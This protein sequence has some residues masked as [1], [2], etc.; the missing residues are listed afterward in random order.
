MDDDWLSLS[1]DSIAHRFRDR[2]LLAMALT[3]PSYSNEGNPDIPDNQR[4]EWL[5]DAVV[6]LTVAAALYERLPDADEG[7]LTLARARVVS[8]HSLAGAARRLDLGLHL[9]LGRGAKNK[10]HAS[11][12]DS[13]LCAAF[14]AVVGAIFLDAGFEAARAFVLRHLDGIMSDTTNQRKDPKTALQEASQANFQSPPRYR[15]VSRGGPDHAPRFEVE[16]TMPDGRSWRGEGRSRREAERDAA[17]A[18]L[19]DLAT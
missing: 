18:A 1:E 19:Q 11:G 4:L 7:R 13:V 14:E 16:V 17:S 15:V 3:H 8:R 5:G 2:S 9:R 12:Q 10:D 6:S